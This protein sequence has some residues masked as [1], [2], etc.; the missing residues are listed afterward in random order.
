M[1]TS[2]SQLRGP[3]RLLVTD[4]DD[5]VWNWFQTWHASFSSMVSEL[6]RLTG[7]PCE[8]LLREIRAIHQHHGTSEYSHIAQEVPSIVDHFDG[9]VDRLMT[10]LDP[11]IHAY[12]KARK[13]TLRLYPNVESTLHELK[14]SGVKVVAYSDSLQYYCAWRLARLGLDGVVDVLYCPPDH[15]LPE[16]SMATPG[17]AERL[18]AATELRSTPAGL[19]K[20]QPEILQAIISDEGFRVDQTVYIGDSGSND[21]AMASAA[22]VTSVLASYK[23]ITDDAYE[24]LQAVSHWTEEKV[25]SERALDVEAVPTFEATQGF[26]E[27]LNFVDFA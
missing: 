1:R 9:D 6:A 11:A 13:A 18:L 14:R 4:L 19:H 24:L 26:A 3:A 7:I 16:G 2:D 17:G 20:P 25:Q 8:S 22:G 21:I 23:E 10:A 15:E 12:R 27:L 5:T